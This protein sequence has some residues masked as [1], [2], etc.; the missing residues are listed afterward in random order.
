MQP[1]ISFSVLNVGR[2]GW[3]RH[4]KPVVYQRASRGLKMALDETFREKG[5]RRCGGLS[6][7]WIK[8]SAHVWNG[9]VFNTPLQ[10]EL[11]LSS[12]PIIPLV[13]SPFH[14]ITVAL[15]VTSSYADPGLVKCVRAQRAVCV[16]WSVVVHAYSQWH[17]AYIC[18]AQRGKACACFTCHIYASRPPAWTIHPT[19]S[20]RAKWNSSLSPF[21]FHSSALILISSLSGLSFFLSLSDNSPSVPSQFCVSLSLTHSLS[22]QS[23]LC[24]INEP[25][26]AFVSQGS[27]AFSVSLS[28]SV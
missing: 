24:V 18:P 8:Q 25:I 4:R 7:E 3:C 11:N 12:L 15:H 21:S 6:K 17:G 2:I 5:G 27:W 14:L 1:K 19:S 16:K 26:S 10:M 28:L 20:L 9:I 13:N 22:L 23:F